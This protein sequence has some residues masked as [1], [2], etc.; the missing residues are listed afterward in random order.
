M[1]ALG[2]LTRLLPPPTWLNLLE[3]NPGNVTISGETDQ[4]ATLL[5]TID[6][7]PL[8]KASEFVQPPLRL[9]NGEGFRVRFRREV[10]LERPAPGLRLRAGRRMPMGA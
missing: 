2:E 1:D 10:L 3:M 4:A 8:F 6:G 9:Q 7:S 5:K